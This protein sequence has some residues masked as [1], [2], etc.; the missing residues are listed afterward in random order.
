MATYSKTKKVKPWQ[1]LLRALRYRNFRLF[2]SGQLISLI[3]TWMQHVALSW[4]IYRLTGSAFMLGMVAFIGQF[5]IFFLTPIAGVY[6]DRHNRHRL[7]LLTQSLAMGLAFILAALVLTDQIRIWHIFAISFMAG[8]IFAFDIPVRHA[9]IAD[10]VERKEDLGNAIALNSSLFNAAR[11]LGPSLAGILIATVGEGICFLVNACSYLT[12]IVALLAMRIKTSGARR[13]QKVMLQ[14]IRDGWQYA[15]KFTSIKMIL[16]LLALM[17]LWGISF[18]VLMPVFARDIFL[19]GPRTLG[20]LYSLAGAGALT[21]AV[22]LAG[23]QNA[24]GLEKIIAGTSHLFA[25]ALI[26]FALS[27]A[28]WFSLVMSFAAGFGMMV[29][30]ASSNTVLQTVVDE[31]KRGRIMSLYAA[32]FMGTM[33]IGSLLAGFLASRIG[34][35]ATL[36]LGGGC[37]LLLAAVFTRRLPALQTEIQPIFTQKGI[38]IHTPAKV[39]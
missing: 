5:P 8:L 22:F 19:G 14:E 30:M 34:A 36:L 33:P 9:F 6:A 21:G 29:Q 37:C 27:P 39:E 13:P 32:A 25:L 35:P 26:F 10:M 24:Y 12:I 20:Y 15:L 2:F 7:L 28:L 17:S 31:D 38:R 1:H 11:L 4:L 18:Q 3:G 16:I 23:R